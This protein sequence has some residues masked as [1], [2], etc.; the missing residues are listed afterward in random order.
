[1]L[2]GEEDLRPGKPELERETEAK[3]RWDI[4]SLWDGG[5]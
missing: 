3:A 5:Y 2:F 4:Q 1:M